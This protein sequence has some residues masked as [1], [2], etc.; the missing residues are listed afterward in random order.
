MDDTTPCFDLND[1]PHFQGVDLTLWVQL[2][3][4][5]LLLLGAGALTWGLAG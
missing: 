5:A 4:V 3:V 1:F 2:A